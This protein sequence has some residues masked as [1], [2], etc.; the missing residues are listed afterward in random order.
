MS[1]AIREMA[2]D[3]KYEDVSRSAGILPVQLFKTYRATVTPERRLMAAVLQEAVR[4]YQRYRSA[5]D[6]RSRRIYLDAEEWFESRD[7]EPL[8]SFENVCTRLAIDADQMRHDLRRW[9]DGE[10]GAGRPATARRVTDA[11][12]REA[13]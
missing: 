10:L 9:R 6:D 8:F 3:Q 13:A 7:P 5:S 2:S 11:A 1:D 12:R 4:A